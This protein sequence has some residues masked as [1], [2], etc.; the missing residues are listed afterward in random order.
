MLKRSLQVMAIGLL[1]VVLS[2]TPASASVKLQ[3]RAAILMEASSGKII[4]EKDADLELPPASLAKIM[5]MLLVMEAVNSGRVALD[6][7]VTAN[8][9]ATRW[10][11]SQIY[12]EPG[13]TMTVADLMKG[14]AIHSANDASAVLAE[15]VAGTQERFVEL[16]NQRAREL[17]MV[18][19][20]YV[21]VHGLDAE[22]QV[23]TVRDMAILSRQAAKTQG[24]LKFTKI[25]QD[26]LRGDATWL[27]NRN[28]L[29]R[30]Y[31]GCDGL[32]TGFTDGAGHCLAATAQRDG[33]RF[34]AVVMGGPTSDVRFSEVS[35]LFNY[36]FAN[37]RAIPIATRGQVVGAV[38]V[39][40]GTDTEI[41][42]VV[43]DDF[44]VTI[45]KGREEGI[46]QAIIL[47]D[48]LEAPLKQGDPVG[49]IVVSQAGK[50]LG[51]T[52]LVSDR[53]VERAS[54]LQLVVRMLR[55]LARF[56]R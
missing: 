5:T 46:E 25:W 53:T 12:L 1:L 26:Y 31:A 18:R 41:M 24:L 28:R 34:I 54:L 45:E 35:T 39:K 29:V 7:R 13:E 47:E 42:A 10:G 32:K 17:G 30:F 20:R 50:Q 36:G 9:T 52:P 49:Y 51:R 27:V 23:T 8:A 56:G 19:T 15:W 2:V 40:R 22:G 3:S 4:F 14:V 16:M 6:D 11:G 21:N 37:F 48:G 44:S 43:P 38:K 55:S 33:C